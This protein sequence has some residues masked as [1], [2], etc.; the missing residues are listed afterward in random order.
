MRQDIAL[1]NLNP[2]VTE[3]LQELMTPMPDPCSH[4]EFNRRMF[5]EA[6]VSK[7]GSGV[8]IAPEDIMEYGSITEREFPIILREYIAK[9]VIVK[10][11]NLF[12]VEMYKLNMKATP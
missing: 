7:A 1:K 6:F 3:A 5:M 8:G 4:G 2:A 10:A 12:G 11:D 9:G